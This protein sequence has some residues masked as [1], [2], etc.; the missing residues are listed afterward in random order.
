VECVPVKR[1]G[2]RYMANCTAGGEDIGPAIIRSGWGFT[3]SVAADTPTKDRDLPVWVEWLQALSTPA[4]A[5]MALVLGVAQWRTAHQRAVL[6]LFERRMAIYD[7]ISAVIGGIVTTGRTTA[8]DASAFT[9]ARQRVELLFGPE[10]P[11]Y[12]EKIDKVMMRHHTAGLRAQN[13]TG[14][15]RNKALDAELRAF[16]ELTAFFNDFGKLVEPYARM[17]QKAPWF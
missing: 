3:P 16:Q 8:Q 17:R 6:D 10:V 4:I 1:V 7:A 5:L 15:D 11:A 14:E 9:R 2:D 13:V 12:L